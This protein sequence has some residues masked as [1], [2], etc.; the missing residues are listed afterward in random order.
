MARLANDESLIRSHMQYAIAAWGGKL[1]KKQMKKI[2]I[3]QNAACRLILNQR[4]RSHTLEMMKKLDILLFPDIYKQAVLANILVLCKPENRSHPL[5]NM[6]DIVENNR[7]SKFNMI[8]K[9][10]SETLN[11][12]IKIYN[13]NIEAINDRH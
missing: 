12:H 7:R 10:K 5:Y 9:L 13:E 6:T 1:N 3:I 4:R 11:K 8:A 2:Q